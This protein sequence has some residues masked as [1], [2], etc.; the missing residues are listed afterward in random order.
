M[1][2][3][4][5]AGAGRTAREALAVVRRLYEAWNAGDVAAAAALLSP[6]VR[7]ETFGD[8]RAAEGPA[9]MQQTLAAPGSHGTWMLSPVSVDVLIGVGGHVVACTRRGTAGPAPEVERLEVW[10]VREGR[11]ARYRGYALDDG[12]AV[13][14]DSTGSRRLEVLCRGLLAASRSQAGDWFARLPGAGRPQDAVVLVEGPGALV[15]SA[16]GE[17]LHLVVAF[18]GDRIRDVALHASPESALAAATH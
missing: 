17:S 8:L 5:G 15:V 2:G 10:T 12:L 3:S 16:A 6:G 14:S 18:D 9:G 11:V 13:L 4:S 1:T 7:W